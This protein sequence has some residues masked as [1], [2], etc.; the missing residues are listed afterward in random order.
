MKEKDLE[1]FITKHAWD[2]PILAEFLEK[3]AVAALKSIGMQVPENFKLRIIVQKEDTI[4][5][6][7]PPAIKSEEIVQQVRTD[8]LMDV[9]SSGNFFTWLIPAALKFNIFKLRNRQRP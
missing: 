3:D 1:Y 8:E 2:D 7:M 4:Y 6:S 9:W 5:L